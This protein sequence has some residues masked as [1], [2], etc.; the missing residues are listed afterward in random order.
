M[1]IQRFRQPV[2]K[3]FVLGAG[4]S[5]ALSNVR[6]RDGRSKRSV[7]PLDATFLNCLHAARPANGWRRRSVNLLL[8]DWLDSSPLLEQGLERAIIKRVS[9]YDLLSALHPQRTKGKSD[10]AK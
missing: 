1:K 3:L 4:A 7:T 8:S 5:Y 6:S 2:E 10:N 9:Q